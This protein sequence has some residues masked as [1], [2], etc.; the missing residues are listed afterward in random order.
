MRQPVHESAENYLKAVL[1]IRREHGFARAVDVSERLGVSKASVSKALSKLERQ[2]L[3][4]VVA[5]DVWLTE[6]GRAVAE[7]VAG[8]HK[9]FFGL[10]R[11]AG[12]EECVADE[13]ACRMEHCLSEDSF[14]KLAASLAARP[15]A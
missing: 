13:E 5:H 11:A 9:F 3:V 12:V 8:R 6:E 15:C 10:L 14:Q 1:A 7:R 2:Q 4:R